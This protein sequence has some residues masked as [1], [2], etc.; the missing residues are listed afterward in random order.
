MRLL[1]AEDERSLSRALVKILEK[2]NYT[3]D[4]VYNGEDALYYMQTQQYDAVI[5]DIMMPKLDGISVL[6]SVRA[7]KNL[8]PILLLTAKSE[9]DDKVTGLDSGA[10]DYLT[11]PFDTKELLARIRV[12]T[13]TQAAAD[14]TITF[15]NVTLNRLT[16]EL[17]TPAASFRLANKEYQIME[18]LMSAPYN[19]IST[20]KLLERVWG[21]DSDAE[22]NVVWVYIS[23]LRKKLSTLNANIQIKA[24]RNSGYALEEMK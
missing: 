6:K 5:L 2:N 19:L 13:R 4:A 15:G 9:I 7:E 12:M 17:K 8:T 3:V 1:L 18:L 10:N 23:Y 16:Y 24:Y 14:S 11:K 22:V 20:E 21:F